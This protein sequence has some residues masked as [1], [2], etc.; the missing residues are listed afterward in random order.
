MHSLIVAS[1]RKIFVTDSVKILFLAAAP[2]AKPRLELDIELRT[3]KE[4]IRVSK[5]R[6]NFYLTDE[7]AVRDGDILQLMNI[8]HP[9][10]VHFSGHGTS[11]GELLFEGDQR[12]TRP[13]PP[14]VLQA[15]LKNFK[16][17]VHLVI[18]NA[19][20]SYTQAKAVA[21]EIDAV[22]GMKHDVSDETAI[23]FI[24]AFYLALGFGES[25]QNAFQQ[26]IT[27]LLIKNISEEDIP[28]LF[29]RPDI[30]ASQITLK[31]L[32][33]TSQPQASPAPQIKARK[34]SGEDK[35]A[36]SPQAKDRPLSIFISYAPKDESYCTDIEKHFSV[37]KRQN[38]I[39]I[40]HM[41]STLGGEVG[42]EKILKYLNA[43]DIVLLLISP[44]FIASDT[45]YENELKP[46]M[47]RRKQGL[48]WVI[49]IIVRET[50]D[51]KRD[52]LIG[53]LLELPRNKKPI[54]N[55][56]NRD[57]AITSIVRDVHKVMER[58]KNPDE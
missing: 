27:Q 47:Y 48:A 43:A 32:A 30:D 37:M 20:H 55:W 3:I 16:R 21:E 6:D 33:Q 25:V 51:W 14:K 19:C 53:D 9:N 42:E 50:S 52:D 54:S 5:Y 38:Q 35:S 58:L 36:M 10:V 2:Y 4:K 24:S 29:T 49:P 41:K 22:I 26:G 15:L 28:Q 39:I 56:D 40:Q 23:V 8:H 44:D 11:T 46:A 1:E 31:E 17:D 57:Q 18:L 12:V 45:L 7:W 34:N 13:I